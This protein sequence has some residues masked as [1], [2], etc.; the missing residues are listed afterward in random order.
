MARTRK[1]AYANKGEVSDSDAPL[2]EGVTGRQDDQGA[3]PGSTSEDEIRKPMPGRPQ[4]EAGGNDVSATGKDETADGLDESEE[5]LR[6]SAEET[7]LGE[8]SEEDIP[9]FERGGTK[10]R[11]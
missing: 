11:V 3:L 7:A 8:Q 6:R 9:V 10:P 2:L 1:S 4:S 5:A